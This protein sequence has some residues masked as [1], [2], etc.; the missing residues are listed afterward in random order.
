[1]GKYEFYWK[2]IE[3]PKRIIQSLFRGNTPTSVLIQREADKFRGEIMLDGFC[4]VRL[5]GWTDVEDDDYCWVYDTK[6]DTGRS[7]G[8][9][10]CCIGFKRL[11][12]KLSGFDYY[13]LDSLWNMNGM[14]YQDGLKRAKDQGIIIK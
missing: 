5:L 13:S 6:G 10:S 11:K 1:M 14:S 4:V 3:R 8:M 12:T 2:F 7:V 9:L